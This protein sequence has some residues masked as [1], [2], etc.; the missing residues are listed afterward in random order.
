MGLS[1]SVPYAVFMALLT[2]GTRGCERCLDTYIS[3]VVLIIDRVRVSPKGG[4]DFGESSLGCQHLPFPL[5]I[6]VDGSMGAFWLDKRR[7]KRVKRLWVKVVHRLF[8]MKVW[9]V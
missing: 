9:G 1:V 6:G 7:S 8:S 5:T 2:E 4:I 3:S